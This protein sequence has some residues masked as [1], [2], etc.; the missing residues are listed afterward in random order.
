LSLLKSLSIN[1]QESLR[2][3]KIV[4]RVGSEYILY[5]EVQELYSYAKAQNAE[6][7]AEVQCQIMEQ[8]IGKSLLLDQAKLDS[9]VISSVE[10]EVELQRRIDYILAQMGG[11][12]ERFY[13]YYNKSPLEQKEVM[14]E[15]LR[16]ELIQQ[17]IQGQLIQDVTITP[18]EAV[19]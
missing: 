5:S 6:Y 7:G 2:L 12:E 8:L 11:S 17:R 18:I 1:A 4:A 10:I 3:E 16:D 14:R 19:Q 9:I 15:P 13:S